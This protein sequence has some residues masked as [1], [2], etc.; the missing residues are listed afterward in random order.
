MLFKQLLIAKLIIEIGLTM[1]MTPSEKAELSYVSRNW[2]KTQVFIFYDKEHSLD[3][4]ADCLGTILS[5]RFILTTAM[6]IALDIF[7]LQHAVITV[8]GTDSYKTLTPDQTNKI[9]TYRVEKFTIHPDLSPPERIFPDLAIL[10][11]IKDIRF[12]LNMHTIKVF[13]SYPLDNP[14]A[15]LLKYRALIPKQPHDIQFFQIITVTYLTGQ[16]RGSLI[17]LRSR[18]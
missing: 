18:F 6:C 14:G 8:L 3:Q 10:K 13:E 1:S 11:L 9:D 5:P 4:V 12:I 15:Y 17:R 16:R 2:H 7:K